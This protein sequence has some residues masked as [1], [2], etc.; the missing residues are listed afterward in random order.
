M[1][2]FHHVSFSYEQDEDMLKDIS[3]SLAPRRRY[4][5][6]GPNGSGKSTL[7]RLACGDLK[8]DAG[9]I[10]VDG[11]EL[12]GATRTQIAQLIGF[13]GQDP[14]SQLVSSTVEDEVAFGPRCLGLS[15]EEIYKRVDCA[16]T[17]CDLLALKKREVGDLSGGEQQRLA[18]AGVIAMNCHYLVLDEVTSQLDI[19]SQARLRIVINKLIAEGVG[20]LEISHRASDVQ[21]ADEVIKV[22]TPANKLKFNRPVILGDKLGPGFCKDKMGSGLVL[23]HVKS[24]YGSH[25]VLDD[26][27]FSFP[28]GQLTLVVG[29]SGAGK[30]TLAQVAAGVKQAEEG[31]VILNGCPVRLGDVGLSFQRPENQFFCDTV[32]DEVGFGPHNQGLEDKEVKIRVDES[33][34]LMGIPSCMQS[35]SPFDLSGGQK[36]LVALASVIALRL[37]AY[38]FD[39]PTA[40]LDANGGKFVRMLTRQLAN[41]GAVVVVVTH[42]IE[43]WREAADSIVELRPC[44]REEEFSHK[45][46]GFGQYVSEEGWLHHRSAVAKVACLIALTIAAFTAHG[47]VMFML[48]FLILA[49]LGKLS[50][51]GVGSIVSSL[52]PAALVLIF[53]LLANALVIDGSFDIQ[54]AGLV[55]LTFVGLIRGLRA[56]VRIVL[57]V[58]FVSVVSA[59]TRP[60]DLANAASYVLR[61]LRRIGVPVTDISVTLSLV[62]RFIPESVAAF[63]R[64]RIAQET[65]GARF[66]QG[67]IRTRLDQWKA[68]LIPLVVEL[69]SRSDEVARSMRARAYTGIGMTEMDLGPDWQGR[70]A[71]GVSIVLCVICIVM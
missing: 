45:V 57:I 46:F 8:P 52:R 34:R 37:E 41:S 13:V 29:R 55:G 17:K 27:T 40:G 64:I 50:G 10:S 14:L 60:P 62:L 15:V 69:F 4:A 63:T 30:S 59:T 51:I 35:R 6:V 65:R 39:E 21:G 12:A 67:S 38:I 19:E 22:G 53:S 48:L 25:T 32:A 9:T 61:P 7:A 54:I 70:A 31:T 43:Q 23:T 49:V 20:V 42:D 33:L 2:I 11:V 68:V 36:R 71:V 1:L 28:A 26:V 66:D 56:V 58:G 3:F 24:S 18:L 5:I 44:G 47:I 16:L